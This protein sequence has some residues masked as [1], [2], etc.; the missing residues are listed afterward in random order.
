MG[1]GD[2]EHPFWI[3]KINFSSGLLPPS[4]MF[5]PIS[6]K[7]LIK[8][9]SLSGGRCGYKDVVIKMWPKWQL[10]PQISLV[11]LINLFVQLMDVELNETV[12]LWEYDLR[13]PNPG[14]II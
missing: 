9:Y 1:L 2:L 13:L 12:L 5:L 7:W 6:Q 11:D 8:L 14:S 10:W 4:S 3:F